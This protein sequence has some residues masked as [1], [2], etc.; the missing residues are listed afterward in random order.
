MLD[1]VLPPEA[2]AQLEEATAIDL[3]FPQTFLTDD[4]V[5]GLIF[6]RTRELIDP[7]AELI[8]PLQ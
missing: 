2:L 8:A 6:G 4:E 1:V 3:G 5:V 7:L